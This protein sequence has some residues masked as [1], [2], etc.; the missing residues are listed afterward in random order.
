M[1][2]TKFDTAAQCLCHNYVSYATISLL[3]QND[4]Y[5]A[6]LKDTG[7]CCRGYKFV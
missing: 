5:G 1:L 7:Q 4:N 3:C 2:V 6:L